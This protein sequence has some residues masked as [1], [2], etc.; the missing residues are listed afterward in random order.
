MKRQIVRII[1]VTKIYQILTHTTFITFILV[2][3]LGAYADD[4]IVV[5]GRKLTGSQWAAWDRC[6]MGASLAGAPDSIC[7]DMLSRFQEENDRAI[8]A[9][10]TVTTCRYTVTECSIETEVPG[11]SL[12]ANVTNS[13]TVEAPT[14]TSCYYQA[15]QRICPGDPGY[16]VENGTLPRGGTVGNTSPVA[17]SAS[18]IN[19]II[20]RYEAQCKPKLTITERCCREPDRCIGN[21][22]GEGSNSA[23]LG[24]IQ[25]VLGATGQASAISGN[26]GNMQNAALMTT[27]LN[28][29]LARN[30]TNKINQCKQACTAIREEASQALAA[31]TAGTTC[32]GMVS[33][34]SRLRVITSE[35][36][37]CE[38]N[39]NYAQQQANQA[40][41]AAMTAKTMGLCKE[42]TT[43]QTQ[44]GGNNVALNNL[45]IDCSNPASASNP[46]CQ[47][48]CNRA[49]AQNDP[50]CNPGLGAGFGSGGGSQLVDPNGKFNPD[51]SALDEIEAGQEALTENIAPVASKASKS[52]PGGGANLPGGGDDGGGGGGLQARGG[53]DENRYLD[54]SSVSSG[55]RSG[56]G[57]VSSVGRSVASKGGSGGLDLSAFAQLGKEG[58]KPFNPKDYLPGGR[59]DPK[60]RLAGLGAANGEIGA[61]HG[62]IF[63]NITNRFYQ[64]CLRDALMDCDSVRQ[65]KKLGK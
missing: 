42:A 8:A 56:N 27:A 28:T 36:R 46:A 30:C 34:R 38:A 57:Y 21:S 44:P 37:S 2:N 39:E 25:A 7:N 60:R 20:D 51:A 26:C 24:S 63:K 9:G 50:A 3:A 52:T 10:Q 14:T 62:D 23:I 12:G 59:L 54:P 55:V 22:D 13:G 53:G 18:N 58:G 31:C 1:I 61:V 49:G 11:N 32:A 45:N 35:E 48:A 6:L 29:A 47:N 4:E 16:V 19:S 17:S 43:A 5:T 33:E 64:V 41:A 40:I 65:A 15:G